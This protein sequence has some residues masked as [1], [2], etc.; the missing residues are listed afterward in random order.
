[1]A[2]REARLEVDGEPVAEDEAGLPNE[3]PCARVARRGYGRVVGGVWCTRAATGARVRVGARAGYW[4]VCVC[5][6]A[7][8]TAGARAPRPV[9]GWM[10]SVL[11]S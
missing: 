9:D 5:V 8:I 2:M 10:R 6:V 3:S 11:F 7:G 4:C 1:M